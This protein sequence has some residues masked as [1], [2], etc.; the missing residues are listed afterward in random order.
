MPTSHREL[1]P[2]AT[3]TDGTGKNPPD[4]SSRRK[5]GGC[6]R[7][8]VSEEQIF[9]AL[10][11]ARCNGIPKTKQ[12]PCGEPGRGTA[13]L[14]L[15]APKAAS[16]VHEALL[17]VIGFEAGMLHPQNE[18]CWNLWASSSSQ[19]PSTSERAELKH[20]EALPVAAVLQSLRPCLGMQTKSRCFPGRSQ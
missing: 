9:P 20:L 4:S 15:A 18:S 17:W 12:N 11:P 5:P 1:L 8:Q 7:R 2:S 14:C 16:L 13:V 10:I 6:L 3:G 19:A